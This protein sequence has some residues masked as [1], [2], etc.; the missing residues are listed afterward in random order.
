[1]RTRAEAVNR[2]V[3]AA[4][5]W[6]IQRLVSRWF[7]RRHG[8]CETSQFSGWYRQDP[9]IVQVTTQKT[10][11]GGLGGSMSIRAK[12]K[13]VSKRVG[14]A[15]VEDSDDSSIIVV[16]KF[17]QATRDSGYKGTESAVAELVD[18]AIQAEARSIWIDISLSGTAPLPVRIAV[19]DD[20]IGMSKHSL[21]QALRFGGSSR[22]ND[23][24]GLGRY[25]MGLPNSS[26]SQARRLEVFTW[27]R[28]GSALWS[29]LDVDEIA[30][31]K[32]SHIPEP[33]PARLP[34]WIA[35]Q[36][37]ESGT[38][39]VWDRC[40]RLDHRRTSSI[41]RRLTAELGRV[42][43]YYLWDGIEIR[44]NGDRVQPVDPL[45]LHPK[46]TRTGATLFGEPIIYDIEIPG[47][48]GKTE[49][50]SG[51]ITVRFSELPVLSWHKL[52]NSEKRKLGVSNG[53]GVSV[54][55]AGREI[56][57][58]WFFMGTKRRENYD[59]WWRCEVR[60]DP[61][62]DEAFGITHT[63]QQIQPQDFLLEILSAD[64]E[65][66]AKALNSRVR[67]AHLNAKLV[68]Q[69]SD[70][71][72]RATKA[73]R[74]L[75]PLPKPTAKQGELF[76]E[77]AKHYPNIADFAESGTTQSYRIVSSDIRDTSFFT[78]TMKEGAFVLVLNQGHPFY[79]KIYLPL[80][81]NET[82]ANKELRANIELLLLAAARAEAAATR[83]PQREFLG[84]TRKAWSDNL[85]TLLNG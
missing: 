32:L 74:L 73:D 60:F 84:Q 20:G 10:F 36:Q 29:Y 81:E 16:E 43:R 80:V 54:V 77:L 24:E 44:V 41:A 35:R 79:K 45:Y 58:G 15:I 9:A 47:V 34:K 53:A 14:S 66:L 13:H 27:R 61:V 6:Q 11:A 19:M 82:P 3:P 68:G 7:E 21:R 57:Y 83:E 33:I 69:T 78:Y 52:S 31:G 49:P 59:D 48:T 8:K 42:F 23:R 17:I 72:Q 30:D 38:L 40:D 12:A 2:P 25:G 26:L 64:I 46:S 76:D 18:N 56:D 1:M 28:L 67:Q 39:V 37:S 50:T 55:R 75:D 51:R 65:G 63:K 70:A 62:L 4:H 5:D 22:F 85:A 71:E